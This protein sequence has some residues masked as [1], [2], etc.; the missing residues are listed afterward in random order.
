MPYFQAENIPIVLDTD[1]ADTRM[2]AEDT[3]YSVIFNE[4]ELFLLGFDHDVS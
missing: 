3:P 4:E 1:N 2:E